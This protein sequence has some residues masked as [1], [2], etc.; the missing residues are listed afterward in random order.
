MIGIEFESHDKAAEVEQAC[1][2]RGL[3]VLGCGDNAIRM[4]PP[5][6]FR[7]DQAEKSIE[8]FAEACASVG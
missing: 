7:R 6:L 1:F 5:L 2:K 8:V 3:L 4:S